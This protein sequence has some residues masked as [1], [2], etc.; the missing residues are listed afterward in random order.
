MNVPDVERMPV[1][2]DVTSRIM[3]NK[4]PIPIELPP[5]EASAGFSAGLPP[6]PAVEFGEPDQTILAWIASH[7]RMANRP[8]MPN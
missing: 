8:R 2:K 6:K 5:I 1:Q 7:V 3:E 4:T